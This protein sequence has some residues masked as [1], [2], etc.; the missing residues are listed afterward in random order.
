MTSEPTTIPAPTGGWNTRD[1]RANMPITDAAIMDNWYPE[2]T[3]VRPRPGATTYASGLGGQAET[4]FSYAGG[5]T[6]K[7]FVAVGGTIQNV[8]TVAGGGTVSGATA[9][10]GYSNDRWQYKNFGTPGGT[11]IVAVNGVDN[12]QIYNGTSWSTGTV[13]SV[14]INAFTNVELY[15]RRLFYTEAN[16]LRVIYHVSTDAIGGTVSTFNLASEMDLGG[17]L[18]MAATW[19]RDGGAGMD[20]LIAFVSSRGQVSVYSGTDPSSAST[21][22]RL[23][24]YKIP[25]PLSPRSYCKFGGEL[26]FATESGVIPMSSIV[27]GLV[28]QPPF[29]DKIISSI[30][31]AV[32][33]YRSHF[34]WELCY[35]P[36]YNWLIVNVPVTTGDSQEQ[37]VMNSQTSA[38]CRF[39]DW[40][41]NTFCI[42]NN[43]VYFGNNGSVV[44]A[45]TSTNSDDGMNIAAD[46]QQAFSAYGGPGR[47]KHFKMFRPLI[48]SDGSVPLAADIN[49]DFSNLTPT[50]IPTTTPL[51]VGIW[52]VSAWDDPYWA[53]DAIPAL[54]WQSCGRLGT[55]G[56][57]RIA[58]QVNGA[59][60]RW[61]GTDLVLEGGGVL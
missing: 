59:A 1:G 16:T 17:Y 58:G 45:G 6:L 44:E 49:V 33:M 50:S 2:S 51:T 10:T 46:C 39:Q 9:A 60:I 48:N 14:T 4:I 7:M 56:A 11:F 42:H 57:V 52:D 18:V 34:G 61:Y 8:S 3:D 31:S 41:A 20:D 32:A 21:W 37:Y 13:S 47:L 29:T 23:G 53:D 54:F 22:T 28:Q 38:W 15:Q 40:N 43:K 36:V 30:N 12:R 27:S 35:A 26:V 5:P 55:Y 25:V 19:T 24:L